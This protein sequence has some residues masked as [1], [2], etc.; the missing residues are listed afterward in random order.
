MVKSY[1]IILFTSQLIKGIKLDVKFLNFSIDESVVLATPTAST[2]YIWAHS[3]LMPLNRK[4]GFAF[5]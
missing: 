1:N 2:S 3:P 5:N 4:V